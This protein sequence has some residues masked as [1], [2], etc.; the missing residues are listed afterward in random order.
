MEINRRHYFRS[1]LHIYIYIYIYIYIKIREY[2]SMGMWVCVRQCGETDRRG[3]RVRQKRGNKR[4][5]GENVE[6]KEKDKQKSLNTHLVVF[7][8]KSYL[9]YEDLFPYHFPTVTRSLSQ[10]LSSKNPLI[11][12]HQFDYWSR[13]SLALI[14]RLTPCTAGGALLADVADPD[15]IS[16]RSSL[17]APS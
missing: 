15:L 12:V 4:K 5:R 14:L 11:S 8:F 16:C 6:Q 13:K 9:V 2:M 17:K 1:V 3:E 10:C 7:T